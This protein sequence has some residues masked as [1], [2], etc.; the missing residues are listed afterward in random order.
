M[1]RA[2]LLVLDSLGIGAAVDAQKFGDAGANTLGHIR[3]FRRSQGGDLRLPNLARM[4]LWRALA[5]SDPSLGS[6]DD[7][8]QQS[9][10]GVVWGVGRACANGKDTTTGHWEMACAPPERP[11]HLFADVQPCF[12]D[13]LTQDLVRQ[14]DLPGLLGNCHASGTEIIERYG[15]AHIAT[16]KPIVYTSADSVIQIAAH[17]TAFGLER[18]YDLCRTARR[19]ADPWAVARV[20]ARPF[21]GQAGSF[22]RTKGRKDF[23]MPPQSPTILD[24]LSH[25][26]RQVITVGKVADIF[27]GSGVSISRP[28]SGIA[29]TFNATLTALRNLEAGGLVFSNIVEFDSDF[30][31]RRDPEGYAQALEQFDQLLPALTAA[32]APDDLLIVTADHGND[33]TWP[34]SDHTREQVPILV[35]AR[36]AKSGTIGLRNFSDIGATIAQH[37]GIRASGPGA[38]F[39]THFKQEDLE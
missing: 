18:L 25:K 29:G 30:G 31:H 22:R 27:A 3:A 9:L 11:F 15:S 35:A 10:S 37:L 20:I 7:G 13:S 36:G 39:L 26:G 32:L 24:D 28:T 19:L 33:P 14:T 21:E 2:V 12:P 23:S 34:G 4:G 38:S 16:G 1:P 5:A 17:E 8:A 6:A